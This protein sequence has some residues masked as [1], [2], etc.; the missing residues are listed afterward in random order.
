MAFILV[1]PSLHIPVF[2]FALLA[3]GVTISPSNP[4]ESDLE[5]SYQVRISDPIITFATS[6]T[7]HKLPRL[8]LNTILQLPLEGQQL[9]LA[10]ISPN[11]C[12]R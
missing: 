8:L 6:S 7:S 2:H 11:N 9:P 1:P 10:T 4:L 3:L 12:Q 5:I